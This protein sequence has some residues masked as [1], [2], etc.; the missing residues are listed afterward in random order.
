MT[1]IKR[2]LTLF[3]IATISA[4]SV[5]VWGE[6]ATFTP[7]S[8][9]AGTLTGAPDGA[10]ATFYNSYSNANQITNNNTQTLTLSGFDGCT[11][12]GVSLN[13]RRSNGGTSA[14]VTVAVG[15]TNLQS[16]TNINLSTTANDYNVTLA[17]TTTSVG[18]DENIVI[19]VKANASSAYVFSYT[20]SY[21]AVSCTNKV[22]ITN[23]SLENNV[24]NGSFTLNKKGEIASCSGDIS[25]S[26][27][28]TPD[29]G[30][31]ASD[32][33]APNS[34]DVTDNGDGTW[35]VTY[36]KNTNA[37][38][39]IGVT[40]SPL[41]SYTIRFFDGATKLKE[42][43]VVSGGTATPPSNPAGCEDFTFIGWWTAE[44][45]KDN[46]TTYTWITD[47]TVTGDQDYYAVYQHAGGGSTIV[48]FDATIDP[49]T[50]GGITLSVTGG[51]L[52]NGTDYRV[53]KNQTMTITSSVGDMSSIVLTFENASNDGGGWAS[54]YSPNAA[55]WT[56]PTADGEQAHIT[57]IAITVG[58]VFYTTTA[59]CR[60]CYEPTLTFGVSEVNKCVGD[61]KFTYTATPENNPMGGTVTYSSNKPTKASVDPSTGEVTILEAMSNEPVTI[62]AT[63]GLVD[64]GVNCQKTAT[65]TY[66]LNI[67][68]KVTWLV[69][70]EEHTAGSPAP[71]TKVVQGG[72]ITQLPS[73]PDGDAVCGGKV[74]IGWTDHAVVDPVAVA[75]TPMYK[76]A[77]DLSSVYINSNTELYAIFA[78]ITPGT[79]TTATY[80]FAI[81]SS[82]FSGTSYDSNNGSHTSTAT[83]TSNPSNTM[84]VSWTSNNVS[85]SSGTQWR[86]SNG[87]IYNSTD[88]GIINSVT[89]SGDALSIYY[90]TSEEPTGTSLGSNDGFFKVA[91]ETG[92]ALHTTSVTVNFTKSSGT[93]DTYSDYS[94]VCGTCLPAPTSPIVTPKS[95]R[96]TITWTAVPDATGYTVT[97]TGG[98]VNVDGTSATITGLAS[99]TSYNFTIRSQGGDPYSC[100]PAY[101]G[102]F[103]TTAC[104]DSP[105]LGIPLVTP[106]TAELSW[107]CEAAT[108]T[109]RV[110]EDAECNTQVGEDHTSCTSPYTI[111][112]LMSNTTYY[113]KIW[114]GGSCVSAVGSFATE[115]IKL[116]IA[117][118]QT[119]A[120][121]VSYNGDADLTLTTYT[122]ETHGDPHANVAEDIFFSKYFEA[123]ASVKLLAIFNGTLNTVDLSNYKLGLAQAGEGTSVKQDFA[124][125]KFSEFV[126]AGG[127]GLTADELELKSNEELILITY[128]D[129]ETDEAIIKC[130]RDDEEHSKFSTYVRLSTPNLQ[131][132]GDDVISL[133]NPE[134]DMIDLIGA[135]TKDGGLDRT[136]AS[137][138]YRSSGVDYN[139][140]MD[141]PGGWY[142]TSGYQ[143]NNDNTETSGYALSSNRCL[144]IRRKHVKSGYA[145]VERNQEDFITLGDYNYLGT[146]YEGEWKGVQIPGS[147]TAYPYAG[148]S[149][150]CDGF[151]VVGSYDYNDYY[152]DFEISGTPTTFEDMKSDPFD[153]TYMI[154]VAD[155]DEKACTQVRIELK[156]GSD[157]LII[158]KDVKVPIMISSDQTTTDAIFHSHYKDASICS[159]C[160]VVILSGASLTKVT[161]GTSGDIPAVRDVKVYQ[162]GQL[163]VPSGTN[164]TIHSLAF[165]RQEDE[166]SSADVKGTLNIN[167]AKGVYLDFL[168]DPT[169]WHYFTLPYDCNVSDITYA[170]GEPATLGTDYLIKRYDGAKRATTQ[171][172]GCWE[173][174]SPS[175]TL[176]KGIG[177]IFAL[178]GEGIVKR[179]FRFP[180]ANEVIADDLNDKT[181]A[182]VYGYGCNDENVRANH[183]GWN[184]LGNPYLLSYT[185]DIESPVLTGE[186]VEDHSEDNPDWNGHYKFND[187]VNDLRYIVV[188]I[189]NGWAGYEQVPLTSYE[190]KP[191]TSY[192]VQI[193]G[194][195][196]NTEQ[197]VSFKQ[198]TLRPSPIVARRP[199]EY[200][201]KEDTHPVWCAVTLTNNKGEKDE[202]ALLISNDF[203]DEYDM[204]D[205]LVKMR[206]TYYQYAQITTKPVLAS[207]NNEGEMAF[208]ALPDS[209]ALAGIPLNYFAAY[210]GEYIFAYDNKY[211]RDGEVKEVKLLDTKTNTW[212]DLM[213]ESYAF[214]SNRE[215]NTTR[216]ILSVRVERKA[217]HIATDLDLTNTPDDQPRKILIN[218][219]VY[220]QRGGAIY[221]VTG[222]QML[223]H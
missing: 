105:V 41:P 122:E 42:E 85:N 173:M 151:E 192:F 64:N 206:G 124:F 180:M 90:G 51:A 171:S 132:N 199:A 148:I 98:T 82:D 56:S 201:E 208:N 140:F 214:T 32:V 147:T 55:S 93:P 68:N 118:W 53:W 96:A 80:E 146:D 202:T 20:I 107:T 40:F 112:S 111:N 195:N 133:L 142:T 84:T 106:T 178:P 211:D 129:A 209:S 157:N 8:R 159:E 22:N 198:S 213:N 203:T 200:E 1:T 24:T 72:Q 184:L 128:T 217:P 127:G 29:V 28:T 79:G 156:D 119:D 194:T 100:F 17:N 94:S 54:S 218:S 114:S 143:A 141:K 11:I 168:V 31:Y 223:N 59:D 16:G 58:S 4:F 103:T 139:G 187:P 152:V 95:N 18:E 186:I 87:Y 65:A 215:D 43:S 149:N 182:G 48:S 63:L 14:R 57:N 222:K 204:M 52:N 78:T 38:S 162:G 161:D 117:E 221:D 163:I 76:T 144:L 86:K 190:M 36:D 174:V 88:L 123:A 113:Y 170:S 3:L 49:A 175:A 21:T 212:Y 44:L 169:N 181:A 131:F 77:S 30:Y 125:K 75:P 196:P 134:G 45:A 19:T 25:V 216:F 23:S 74:F 15:E 67:Y 197:G 110:Y 61:N 69:N 130:A 210:Q 207:R 138:I 66:T 135:G 27:T 39:L 160:D 179:E 81:T 167:E 189:A 35:T 154:P 177:Y 10:S 164:Y 99:E 193:G 7:S 50:K 155:L 101:H 108:T 13:M 176:K 183:R 145:A 12:T 153:G 158:R 137:F 136:G 46:T 89:I 26:V 97:C 185:S 120:V 71:T 73:N 219:H 92:G 2:F 102:S 70:D 121:V 115:E 83:D 165:R 109:I 6:T 205:D 34:S 126:K 47:F 91:N 62:T 37:S 33:S 172:T 191:F 166:I 9:S 150:S 104:E 220:I 116:D 188:P 5:H 60:S